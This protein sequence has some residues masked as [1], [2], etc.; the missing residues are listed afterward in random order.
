MKLRRNLE[1]EILRR[2]KFY[3]GTGF[4]C[5][6]YEEVMEFDDDATDEEI[7]ECHR[8]WYEGKL[9]ASWWDIEGDN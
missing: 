2:V 9:D 6:S 5:S 1:V 3:L 8:D 4:S 7:S